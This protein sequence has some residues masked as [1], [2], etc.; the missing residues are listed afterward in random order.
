MAVI[1]FDIDSLRAP[2]GGSALGQIW[3]EFSGRAIPCP[4]WDD[5][6]VFVLDWW[7]RGI[8]DILMGADVTTPFAFMD[9]EY[10]FHAVKSA[11]GFTFRCYYQQEE[12]FSGFEDQAGTKEFVAS[13]F[14]VVRAVTE[15]ITQDPKW[16]Q[17]YSGSAGTLD[18]IIEAQPRLDLLMAKYVSGT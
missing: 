8:E 10:D 14:A 2:D 13:Y 16:R 9:S 7:R 6:I 17:T 11:G 18:L 3:L 12:I 4:R 5:F 1:R 15:R